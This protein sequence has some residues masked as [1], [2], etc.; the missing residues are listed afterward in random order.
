[1]NPL[2]S[3]LYTLNYPKHDS[4]PTFVYLKNVDFVSICEI[5]TRYY[6]EVFMK[7]F[8]L[9]YAYGSANIYTEIKADLGNRFDFHAFD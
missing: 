4:Y 5:F 3:T 2:Y 9:P 1:M 7:V 8:A 6:E